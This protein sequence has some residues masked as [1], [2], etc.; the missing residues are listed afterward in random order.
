MENLCR[1]AMEVMGAGYV[2]F[3]GEICLYILSVITTL[4]LIWYMEKK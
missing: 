3:P 1:L 2:F 4:A